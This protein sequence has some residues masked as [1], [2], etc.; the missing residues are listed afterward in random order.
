MTFECPMPKRFRLLSELPG[1]DEPTV[2]EDAV[3]VG[4]DTVQAV[5]RDAGAGLHL[6]GWDWE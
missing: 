2:Q 4:A 1:E 3:M 6:I 5:L